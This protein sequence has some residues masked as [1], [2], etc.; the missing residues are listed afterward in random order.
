MPG[1]GGVVVGPSIREGL[2]EV[3]SVSSGAGKVTDSHTNQA[4]NILSIY[5]DHSFCG[6]LRCQ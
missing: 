5:V 4:H 3:A 2:F 1:I 6:Y